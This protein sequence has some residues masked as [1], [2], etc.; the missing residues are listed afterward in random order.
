MPGGLDRDNYNTHKDPKVKIW[1][2][3]RPRYHIHY[4]PTH[5]SW[6]NQV[7]AGSPSPPSRQFGA[8]RSATSYELGETIDA[9]VARYNLHH[10][11]FAWTATADSILAKLQRLCKGIVGT[12]HYDSVK[13]H[14]R[15]M[16]A[17]AGQASYAFTASIA[18][19]QRRASSVLMTG[20][21]DA[22]AQRVTAQAF[23]RRGVIFPKATDE[24]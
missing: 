18:E 6:L 2:A 14:G 7:K 9:Y 22:I 12:S 24:W 8:G 19:S 11:P 1:L 15:W 5:A 23:G 21:A 20:V 10:Q 17:A 13:V 16:S 4:T 3:R